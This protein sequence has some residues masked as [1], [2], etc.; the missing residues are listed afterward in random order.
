M[1][2]RDEWL[3]RMKDER[4]AEQKR[5]RAALKQDPRV[6]AMKAK[7]K[8]RQRAASDVQKQRRKERA[9]EEKR[10]KSERERDERFGRAAALLTLVRPTGTQKT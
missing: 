5:R 6:L 10:Q 8:E 2:T 7:V 1:E 3:A 9:K 4:R